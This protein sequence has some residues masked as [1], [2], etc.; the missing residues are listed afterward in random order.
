MIG[1]VCGPIGSS[2]PSLIA[3]V[4]G[5]PDPDDPAVLDA[6]VGLDDAD[7]GIDDE[8]AGDD[9]VELRRARPALGRARPEG[10]RVAPDRLVAGRLAVLL[11]ADPEVG[12]AEADAVAGRR[13]VAGEAFLRGEPAHGR[14]VAPSPRV[15]DQADGPR[16]A[17]R[18]A[19]GRAGREVQAE[20]RSPPRGRTPAAG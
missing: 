19:L 8:R 20:A 11:D 12:V 13:A 9:D 2:M 16:L 1:W 15:A 3:G 7:D 10:L 4:A 6:D 5:P 18:P 17:G 14:P